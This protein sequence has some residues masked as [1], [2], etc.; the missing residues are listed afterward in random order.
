MKKYTKRIIRELRKITPLYRLLLYLKTEPVF[1]YDQKCYVSQSR[2][3]MR[4]NDQLC[5]NLLLLT[6][7]LEKGMSF[8]SLRPFGSEKILEIVDT[9]NKL[10]RLGGFKNKTAFVITINT[11]RKYVKIYEENGWDNRCEYIEAKKL[12]EKYADVEK[13]EVGVRVLN[14]DEILASN[15]DYEKFIRGRHSIRKFAVR[16]LSEDD[17]KRAVEVARLTPSACNRQMIRIY[18]VKSSAAD[19]KVKK[20]MRGNLSGFDVNTAHPI[21]VTFDNSAWH[22]AYERSQGYLN[23]GFFAMNLVHAMHSLGIGSCFCE[24]QQPIKIEKALKKELNIPE[25]ERIAVVIMA[26]YYLDKNKVYLS[27][28]IKVDEIYRER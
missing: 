19:K 16:K 15:I 28:R 27:P 3:N 6:H 11:L 5:Y 23:A 24:F 1:R 18:S 7:T 9:I 22:G 2:G 4:T 25:S 21:I 12:I 20:V 13:I 10:E 17:I 26:G 8:D 14:K